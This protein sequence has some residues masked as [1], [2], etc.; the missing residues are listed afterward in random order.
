MDEADD[1]VIANA[2]CSDKIKHLDRTNCSYNLTT[3]QPQ[4]SHLFHF[5]PELLQ[6]D[7]RTFAEECSECLEKLCITQVSTDIRKNGVSFESFVHW[8]KEEV[9]F[10]RF[11]TTES[12]VPSAHLFLVGVDR[13]QFVLA[14]EGGASTGQGQR[15]VKYCREEIGAGGVARTGRQATPGGRRGGVGKGERG[16]EAVD[17]EGQ[18]GWG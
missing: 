9:A 12:K 14:I 15:G 13:E 5:V 10:T 17:R 8:R 4:S 6:V 16:E 18:I 7:S 3:I 11:L 1:K 2:F